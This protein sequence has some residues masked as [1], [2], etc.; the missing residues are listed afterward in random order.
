MNKI[1]YPRILHF[2]GS[3]GVS[4]DDKMHTSHDQWEG[5][6]VVVTEKCDGECTT[7][8]RD[9]I[10]ARSLDYNPHPSRTFVKSLWANIAHDIPE[11]FRVVGENVTAMHSIEYH[12][13][14]SYF[15]VFNVWDGN[16]CLSWDET[17]QYTSLL[18]LHTVPVLYRGLWKAELVQEL[19]ASIDTDKQE[20]FVLRP[21]GEFYLKDFSKLVGKW[22]RASHVKTPSHWM[23]E[24]IKLN[25][26]RK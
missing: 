6:Q 19:A 23:R 26:L 3:P 10:H 12:D 18:W 13:L 25:G 7:W 16:R 22:V 1:K 20:G 9:Y 11:N 8:A 2:I 24:E 5:M 21:A 17:V 4:N 15:L 14:P